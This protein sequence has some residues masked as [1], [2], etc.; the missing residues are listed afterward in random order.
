MKPKMYEAQHK[1]AQSKGKEFKTKK[2]PEI[3]QGLT[4]LSLVSTVAPILFKGTKKPRKKPGLTI[5]FIESYYLWVA[6]YKKSLNWGHP[7]QRIFFD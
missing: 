7:N 1:N 6:R 2:A 5:K 4:N 3:N